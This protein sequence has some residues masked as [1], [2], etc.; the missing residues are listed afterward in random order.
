M[1]DA[2]ISKN[3]VFSKM[4]ALQPEDVAFSIVHA[5]T[6]PPHVEINEITIQAKQGPSTS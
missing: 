2:A 4:P 3:S 5:L 6:V 1:M